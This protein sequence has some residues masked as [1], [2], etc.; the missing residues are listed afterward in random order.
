MVSREF[1]QIISAHVPGSIR[2]RGGFSKRDFFD[3]IRAKS[4]VHNWRAATSTANSC[5]NIDIRSRLCTALRN[6]IAAILQDMEPRQV[7]LQRMSLQISGASRANVKLKATQ[8]K[9]TSS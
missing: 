2:W 1:N 9:S 3:L 4:A 8:F 5:N 6:R 7:T